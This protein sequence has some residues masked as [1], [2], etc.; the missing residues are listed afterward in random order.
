MITPCLSAM[1]TSQFLTVDSLWAIMSEV[2]PL[3]TSSMACWT[4]FSV[5]VSRAEVASSKHMILDFLS[6]ALAMATLYF[7]PPE[8]LRPLSPTTSSYPLFFFTMN[9]WNWAF[10]EAGTILSRSSSFFLGSSTSFLKLS[11]LTPP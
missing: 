7:S 5:S 2:E 10:W 4:C 3:E 6:R 9:W 8:S 1:M 11:S